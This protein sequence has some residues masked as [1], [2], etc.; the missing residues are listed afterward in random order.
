MFNLI[1]FCLIS[2]IARITTDQVCEILLRNYVKK[3]G[4]LYIKNDGNLIDRKKISSKIIEKFLRPISNVL[5]IIE[6]ILWTVFILTRKG[7]GRENLFHEAISDLHCIKLKQAI[8]EQDKLLKNTLKIDLDNVSQQD[9]N[10]E[11]KKTC[12]NSDSPY[13]GNYII[14]KKQRR[15]LNAMN[16]AELW[17]TMI[18]M[19]TNITEA[20]KKELFID[21]IKDFKNMKENAKPKAIEK[22]MKIIHSRQD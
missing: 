21:Y 18:Q 12:I 16:E 2:G 6:E 4:Y 9:I 14:T 5:E 13:R 19:D 11:Y 8:D 1:I 3:Y 22:T 10:H 15:T 20:E 17:L 7:K